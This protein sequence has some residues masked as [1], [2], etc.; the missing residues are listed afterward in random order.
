MTVKPK[1]RWPTILALSAAAFVDSSENEQVSRETSHRTTE[2]IFYL[3]R[4]KVVH[5]STRSV[6][7]LN[8]P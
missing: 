3:S 4:V 1:R 5:V 6:S 7:R 2:H 8:H